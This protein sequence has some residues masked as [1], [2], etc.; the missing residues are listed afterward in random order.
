MRARRTAPQ[1]VAL[2]FLQACVGGDDDRARLLLR[3]LRGSHGDDEYTSTNLPSS[4]RT[5]KSF[6]RICKSGV[7]VGAT[8][9]G[10]R[11]PWRCSR[12]AWHAARSRRPAPALRLV[13]NELRVEE[14]ADLA[15]RGSR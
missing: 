2:A 9:D 3:E 12:E 6:A 14:L 10:P 7:I 11:G 8:Q 4:I 5:A 13:S 1:S 15:I